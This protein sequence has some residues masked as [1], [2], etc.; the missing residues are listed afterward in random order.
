MMTREEY[1]AAEVKKEKISKEMYYAK[2][3]NFRVWLEERGLW[4][5]RIESKK[6]KKMFSEFVRLWN[7]GSLSTGS[8]IGRRIRSEKDKQEE[9][10][11]NDGEV[12]M[13][14]HKWVFRNVD[15]DELSRVVQEVSTETCITLNNDEQ[16]NNYQIEI[17][18][19]D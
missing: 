12:P 15:K 10:D 3:K 17:E 19:K 1:E 18:N 6:Q 8:Y 13:T 4:L 11:G 9:D 2:N 14:K 16:F 5:D 7:N